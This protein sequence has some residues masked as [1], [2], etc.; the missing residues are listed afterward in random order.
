MTKLLTST[1]SAC[2]TAL[3][4]IIIYISNPILIQKTRL[5]SL[6]YYQN[7]GNNYES[8][9]LILLDIS[10]NALKK[11]GQ[12]PWKRDMVGRAVI[13][14]YKNG[15][16]LVFVNL[17]FVHKDRLGGDEM[18]LKMI[19]KYPIILTETKDA[20]NLISIKRKVLGVGDVEVPIDVDLKNSVP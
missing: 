4:L 10:D 2:L 17:V 18:F 9:S 13:N 11:Q 1:W 6:D 14:A 3:I 15:A 19:S 8:K 16:A 12:W 5:S 20:K 7:F